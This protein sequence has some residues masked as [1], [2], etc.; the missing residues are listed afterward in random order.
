[1][2]VHIRCRSRV[3]L[4]RLVPAFPMSI[5][6]SGGDQRLSRRGYE[7]PLRDGQPVRIP[8]FESVDLQLTGSLFSPSRCTLELSQA[9][10][11]GYGPFSDVRNEDVDGKILYLRELISG[12]VFQQPQEDW[13]AAKMAGALQ[14]SPSRIRS[15]LFMQGVA[16]TQLCRTQRLMRAL[17]ESF[18]FDLSVSDLKAR[19]GWS[20]NHDLEASFHEWFGVSLQT[21]SRLRE[22]CL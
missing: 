13:N 5:T 3:T 10:A 8:A 12:S 15:R 6:A 20:E 9:P 4:H 16:F 22:D 18:R 21:I 7:R 2:Q 17:F 14:T 1:M 11:L 19:V